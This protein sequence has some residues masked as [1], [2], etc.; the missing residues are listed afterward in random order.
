MPRQADLFR[1]EEELNKKKK[2]R[3]PG[4]AKKT[5]R[6]V[7]LGVLLDLP[8]GWELNSMAKAPMDDCPRYR[9]NRHG[10]FSGPK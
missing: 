9:Q 5:T 4:M 7:F 1:L 3:R 2:I 6:P 8:T 10:Y